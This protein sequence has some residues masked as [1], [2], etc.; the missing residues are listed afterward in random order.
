MFDK[1]QFWVILATIALGGVI[2]GFGYARH[3]SGWI[4]PEKKADWLV[5][6]ASKELDLSTDQKAKLNQ[7]KDEVLAKMQTF[8]GLREGLREEVLS[9]VRKESVDQQK[10][11][12]LLGEKEAQIKE[13]RTFLVAKFAEFHGM[14]TPEQRLKLAE[15]LDRFHKERD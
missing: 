10:L 5:E 11:N 14:L 6:I 8:R 13:M 2:A 1:P 12:Q 15:G 9:Q 4:S 3:G 7:I